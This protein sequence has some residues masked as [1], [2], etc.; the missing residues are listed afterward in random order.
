MK[1]KQK[2]WCDEI[3]QNKEHVLLPCAETHH[4]G[5]WRSRATSEFSR[6]FGVQKIYLTTAVEHLHA[7]V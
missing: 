4:A 5:T 6:F 7:S 2:R 3:S 1:T